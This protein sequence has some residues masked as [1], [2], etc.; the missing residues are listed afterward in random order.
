MRRYIVCMCA[1]ACAFKLSTF[2]RFAKNFFT[3]L[4][5]LQK[6][7]YPRLV[8]W[9]YPFFQAV[10][11]F[12]ANTLSPRTNVVLGAF[13]TILIFLIPYP[14]T[15]LQ[16]AEEAGIQRHSSYSNYSNPSLV[17]VVLESLSRAFASG[18]HSD[19]S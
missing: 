9:Q 7:R 5:Y 3:S 19:V 1:C 2:R 8:P 10:R 16:S 17:A 15:A 4:R 13:L 18:C 11:D 14:L 6:Q 12:H